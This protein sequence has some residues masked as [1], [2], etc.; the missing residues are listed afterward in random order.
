MTMH[1]DDMKELGIV[2]GATVRVRTEIGEATFQCKEG[3]VPRGL[4]LRPLRPADVPAHGRRDRRHRHADVEGL[5]SRSGS[6]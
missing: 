5:G 4:D 3:K 2:A 1:A 6:G